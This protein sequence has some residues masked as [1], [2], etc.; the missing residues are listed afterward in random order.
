MSPSA[1]STSAWQTA[2]T[3]PTTMSIPPTCRRTRPSNRICPAIPTSSTSTVGN[4]CH[5]GNSST[6]PATRSPGRSNTLA[7]SGDRSC[8]SRFPR[9]TSLSTGAPA[10][11]STTG[12]ITTP[13]RRR[14][15]TARSRTTTSGPIHWWRS[16]PATST[17]T[18]P[19]TR[20]ASRGQSSQS[21]E[22]RNAS[23]SP[24][25]ASATSSPIPQ[26]SRTTRTSSGPT[27]GATPAP[28]TTSILQPASLT[29]RK[30]CPWGTM[31]AYSRSSG[32]TGRTP[33]RRPATG[34]SSLTRSTT[35]PS[36]S[37]ASPAADRS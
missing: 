29:S 16:G 35:T 15:S 11:C 1:T 26:L 12:C 30:W 9:R 14:R 3:K 6:S 22:G 19:M 27:R 34:S 37:A 13:A 33:R 4:R 24:R 17:P 10:R 36:W 23:I 20:N 8:L 28:D 5:C 18:D 21:A 31:R 7:P 2:P 32:R 25:P